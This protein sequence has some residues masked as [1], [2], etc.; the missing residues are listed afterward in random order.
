MVGFVAMVCRFFWFFA[1]EASSV[2][3]VVGIR[4]AAVAAYLYFLYLWFVYTA[5]RSIRYRGM[6]GKWVPH[7]LA[8]WAADYPVE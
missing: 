6:R 5:V 1:D 4:T 2:P 8:Q 3:M 7:G